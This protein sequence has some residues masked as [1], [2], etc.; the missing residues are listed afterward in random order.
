MKLLLLIL[1]NYLFVNMDLL[2]NTSVVLE[3][4]CLVVL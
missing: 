3:C 4:L 2:C 1:L